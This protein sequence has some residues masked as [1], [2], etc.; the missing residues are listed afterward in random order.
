IGAENARAADFGPIDAT[1]SS[2]SKNS[3][4]IALV[5]PKKLY[6]PAFPSSAKCGWIS[7][8]TAPLAGSL[9]AT[10][11]GTTTSYTSPATSMRTTSATSSTTS[12][13]MRVNTGLDELRGT[14]AA[15]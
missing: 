13:E 15:L 5:N 1:D 9:S 10:L 14:G 7:S 11:G 3:R 2:A 8:V 12:P 6:R 4:S